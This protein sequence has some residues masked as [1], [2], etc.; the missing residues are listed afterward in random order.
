MPSSAAT[1]RANKVFR[2]LAVSIPPTRIICDKN[3]SF[4][5]KATP[6]ICD[7]ERE[8]IWRI[9]EENMYELYQSSSFGWKPQRKRTEMF[10]PLSRFIVARG[11]SV[12]TSNL[13]SSGVVAY[14]IFRFDREDRQNV[15]YC[16]EL[17]VS[18]DSRRF[19]LG[20][21]LTQILSDIGAQW[22]MTKVMLTVF[23][24]S[25]KVH[26]AH[27]V[28]HV[29][30]ANH[31]AML[32]YKSIGFTIDEISPDFTKDPEGGAK[33]D[34]ELFYLHL[35]TRLYHFLAERDRNRTTAAE[36]VPLMPP[37]LRVLTVVPR[38]ALGHRYASHGA[39]HYNEPTGWLFGEKVMSF[40]SHA[41]PQLNPHTFQPLPPGQ[42]RVKEDWE[43]IWYFGMFGSMALAAILLYYKPDTSIQTWALK[44]A[45]ERMEARG[46]KYKYDSKSSS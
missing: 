32:F 12:P 37:H 8:Q 44:E 7:D 18:K 20:R 3:F 41:V 27:D 34:T 33:D 15:I 4:S 29:S 39:P 21:L 19:G 24:G 2:D 46:E 42:K 6:D 31:T 26:L 9:F 45:K 22:G 38:R 1:R 43:N 28:A 35:F 17:Q 25:P 13:A 16:Y 11:F 40:H 30:V 14:S 36:L 5:V 10:D 23:K